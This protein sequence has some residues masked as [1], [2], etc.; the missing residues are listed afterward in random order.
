MIQKVI[1]G[2]IAKQ[3]LST[4][5]TVTTASSGLHLRYIRYCKHQY[6]NKNKTWIEKASHNLQGSRK[7]NE[8]QLMERPS[9]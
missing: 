8:G 3:Q 1:K 4:L 2:H 9:E 7:A 6:C 5:F